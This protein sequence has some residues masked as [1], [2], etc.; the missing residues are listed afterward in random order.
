MQVAA[1]RV[2]QRARFRFARTRWRATQACREAAARQRRRCGGATVRWG[3]TQPIALRCA[4]QGGTRIASAL[5]MRGCIDVGPRLAIILLALAGCASQNWAVDASGDVH[6]DNVTGDASGDIVTGDTA[7]VLTDTPRSDSAFDA[8]DDASVDAR[9]CPD[10]GTTC[11]TQCSDTSSDP[12]HCGSCTND[13]TTLPG[14]NAA[15]VGCI[16]GVCDLPDGC[17]P[18]RAHCS[19]AASD[20]CETDLTLPA[21]CGSCA[22]TCPATAAICSMAAGS[23]YACSNGCTAPTGTRCGTL[24]VDTTN[25]I[26][27]C[28]ACGTRCLTGEECR[29]GTCSRPCVPGSGVA[30]IDLRVV[31][32]PEPVVPGDR[33]SLY[34][35]SMRHSRV[36]HP[37]TVAA[38][39]FVGPPKGQGA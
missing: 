22:T 29:A 18:N 39:R 5:V 16:A 17:L 7:D 30:S 24:C 20:G 26:A 3:Q 11:G 14:V 2:R 33:V 34:L 31:L 23:G 28:G 25:D 12:R 9:L 37:S 13:C 8:T 27:N 10:G 6:G 36:R 38:R 4:A 1:Q 15:S 35:G 21:H 19:T 32:A